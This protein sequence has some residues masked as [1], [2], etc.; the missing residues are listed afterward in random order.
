MRTSCKWNLS[1]RPNSWAFPDA[2]DDPCMHDLS[3]SLQAWRKNPL[4]TPTTSFCSLLLSREKKYENTK[5]CMG[6]YWSYLPGLS[7]SNIKCS[8]HILKRAT[9]KMHARKCYERW[10]CQLQL[11][12]CFCQRQKTWQQNH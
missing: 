8:T 1:L 12:T 2:P 3:R 11:R 5:H 7:W 6:S 9:A 10:W 4:Y